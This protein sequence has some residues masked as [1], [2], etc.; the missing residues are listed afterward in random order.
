MSIS[1]IVYCTCDILQMD[2]VA[3]RPLTMSA[4]LLYFLTYLFNLPATVQLPWLLSVVV[5]PSTAKLACS[6]LDAPE[7]ELC[8]AGFSKATLNGAPVGTKLTDFNLM[9]QPKTRGSNIDI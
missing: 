8:N 9:Q 1:L 2:L 5:S 3:V 4:W 6:P 7:V